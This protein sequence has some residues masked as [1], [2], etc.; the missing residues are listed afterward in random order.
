M[1]DVFQWM[2]EHWAFCLFCLTCIIQITPAIKWNPITA[3]VKWL[4]KVI[5]QPAMDKLGKVENEIEQIKT[6][7]RLLRAERKADEKDRIRYEV[8]YF[9]NSCRNGRMHTRD[10]FQHII[11]LND[12]YERLLAE[13]NDTNGVFTEEYRYI[14]DLY[15]KCQVENDFL[16]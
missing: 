9:A 4:G 8:L 3:F 5:I 16:K 10:E 1:Q 11:D 7:Q 15:H 13:T 14:L 12:K 2:Q 6:E